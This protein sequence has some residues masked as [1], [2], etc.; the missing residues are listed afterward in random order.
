MFRQIR[1]YLDNQQEFLTR[2]A[3]KYLILKDNNVAGI[4]NTRDE[5]Y[6]AALDKFTPGTF[7]IQ[8]CVKIG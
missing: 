7:I 2:Y 4:Y 6:N 8:H 5:A 3:G 1:Y